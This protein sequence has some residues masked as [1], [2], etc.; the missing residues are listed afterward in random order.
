[1]AVTS[2]TE[3]GDAVSQLQIPASLLKTDIVESDSVH[4]IIS[5][6]QGVCESASLDHQVRPSDYFVWY[7]SKPMSSCTASQF[8]LKAVALGR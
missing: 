4:S 1:M 6:K 8:S 7:H 3:V 2:L 5:E